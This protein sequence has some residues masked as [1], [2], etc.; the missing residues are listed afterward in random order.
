MDQDYYRRQ[1]PGN[2]PTGQRWNPEGLP[3]WYLDLIGA[4][5]ANLTVWRD[6]APPQRL[7]PR[8]DPRGPRYSPLRRA[9]T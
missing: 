1:R 5:A 9:V 7:D 8:C 6:H 3:P 4:V 2:W